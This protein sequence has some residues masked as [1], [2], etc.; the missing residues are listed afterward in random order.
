MRTSRLIPFAVPIHKPQTQLQWAVSWFRIQHPFKC[1][2]CGC[3]LIKYADRLWNPECRA[4]RT[5]DHVVPKSMGGSS[6][7]N[8]MLPCCPTCNGLKSN[9]P[10]E[11]YRKSAFG[12]SHKF[13]FEKL[14]DAW[15]ACS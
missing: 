13:T 15:K 14:W 12:D 10:L 8:N 11:D 9:I 2:Y 1:G 5:Y 3:G 6:H 4:K 7:A